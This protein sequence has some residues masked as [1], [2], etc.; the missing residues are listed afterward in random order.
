MGDRVVG[1]LHTA[2]GAARWADL[3]STSQDARRLRSAVTEGRVT[4]VGRGTYVLPGTDLAVAAACLYRA[5]LTC[6]TLAAALGLAQLVPPTEPHLSIPRERGAVS[7]RAGVRVRLHR[8]SG[9]PAHGHRVETAHGLARL[10][11]CQEPDAALVSIDDALHRG[12]VTRQGLDRALPAGCPRRARQTL[13]LAD[14]RSMSPLETLAR[15][16]L[17]RDGLAVEPAARIPG[18]GE[19][20]LLVEG[21]VV[22]ELDG[23]AYHSGRHE[24]REDR[25]RDREL[26]ARGMVVL[27]FAFEDVRRA[28]LVRAVRAVL[29][30]GPR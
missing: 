10:L 7:G 5:D 6:V 28:T 2:G 23:F 25:R 12:I 9:V 17:L 29:A 26:A 24:Y 1:R 13:E 4:Q 20:D 8:E 11:L 22:V 18:V 14:G 3:V 16:V 15:L 19:V 21:W 30:R 27:R